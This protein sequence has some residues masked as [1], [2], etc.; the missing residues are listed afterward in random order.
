VVRERVIRS[1]LAALVHTFY[2]VR[3]AGRENLPSRGGALLV[4]NHLS[5]VDAAFVLAASRRPIR[6]LMHGDL[7]ATAWLGPF[8]RLAQ[9]IPISGRAAPSAIVRA[10]DRAREV[11]RRGEVVCV[12]AEGEISRTGRLLPFARGLERIM[13]GL[14]APIVPVCLDGLWGSVFSFSK[15]RFFWKLPERPFDLVSVRFGRPLAPT[16]RAWEVRLAVQALMGR[17]GPL[18]GI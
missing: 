4:S 12:F 10:L 16:T 18:A 14:D 2:R 5:F 3:I 11:V 15:G 13:R 1:V 6:F 9:A 17:A 8:A 7:Y